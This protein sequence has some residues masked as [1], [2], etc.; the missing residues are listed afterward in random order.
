MSPSRELWLCCS[1]RD[2]AALG[3][4]VV[5]SVEG[6]FLRAIDLAFVPT[7]I[8]FA[9]KG[10]DVEAVF[11]AG[12]GKMAKLAPDGKPLTVIDAP[13]I[14]NREEVLALMKEEARKQV[15]DL[16]VGVEKQKERVKK[17]IVQLKQR[18]I[19]ETTDQETKRLRRLKLL[20]QQVKQIQ[21][22]ID[23]VNSGEAGVN[24]SSLASLERA[25]GLAVTSEHVFVSLPMVV[26]NGYDVWR[27]NHG[28]ASATKVLERG[29]ESAANLTFNP[30]GPIWS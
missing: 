7:A 23:S 11:V 3:K 16:L 21:I 24:E 15:G 28:L 18:Q 5:H 8:G 17:Q 13:N 19:G 10:N 12:S 22:T 14:G 27:L 4:I 25:T 30:M 1:S 20:Q 29:A 6:K 9:S 26:G 2:N